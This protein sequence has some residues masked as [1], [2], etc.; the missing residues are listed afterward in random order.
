M[1]KTIIQIETIDRERQVRCFNAS[2]FDSSK[3]KPSLGKLRP[4][5]LLSLSSSR[6]QS[7]PS[8]SLLHRPE[9]DA[10]HDPSQAGRRTPSLCRQGYDEPA[11]APVRDFCFVGKRLC[12]WSGGY[13]RH[14]CTFTLPHH[15]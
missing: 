1:T 5:L 12:R 10:L 15:E 8:R 11:S 3:K 6:N 2:L 7:Q 13:R 14:P 4:Q 9:P